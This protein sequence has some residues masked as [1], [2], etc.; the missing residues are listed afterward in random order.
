MEIIH[1]YKS[2][3]VIISLNEI[4]WQNIPDSFICAAYGLV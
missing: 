1:A 4:S 3:Y 2:Y